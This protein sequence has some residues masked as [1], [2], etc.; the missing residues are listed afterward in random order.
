MRSLKDNLVNVI[1][2]KGFTGYAKVKRELRLEDVGS[3][4][5]LQAGGPQ[6]RY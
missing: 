1:G 4:S 5:V 6:G 2:A 3:L